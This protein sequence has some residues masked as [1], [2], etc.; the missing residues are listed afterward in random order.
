VQQAVIS[1]IG[2]DRPGIAASIT[3]VLFEHGRNVADSH[4]GLLNGRFSM[5]LVVTTPPGL[6][7]LKFAEDL[8]AA[9]KALDLSETELFRRLRNGATLADIAEAQNTS[10]ADV[11][12]AARAAAEKA[13]DDDVRAGRLTRAEADALLDRIVDGIARFPADRPFGRR[14]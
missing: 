4:M 3:R 9:A 5:M 12:A 2:P 10:L 14:P 6:R 1:A 8:E 13:L 7:E 11:R